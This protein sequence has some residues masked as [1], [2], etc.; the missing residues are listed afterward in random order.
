MLNFKEGKMASVIAIKDMVNTETQVEE[1]IKVIGREDKRLLNEL[2]YL[3]EFEPNNGVFREDRNGN[4]LIYIIDPLF[5]FSKDDEM[6]FEPLGFAIF[7]ILE[8][9]AEHGYK[10]III[11]TLNGWNNAEDKEYVAEVT[12]NYIK[13]CLDKEGNPFDEIIINL[14]NKETFNFF[15]KAL[16]EFKELPIKLEEV[17][18]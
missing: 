2:K 11:P 7:T 17:A 9:A 14:N 16:E 18:Q 8:T 12:F 3:H 6:G 4:A 5:S 10:K 1:F 13:Y 15:N